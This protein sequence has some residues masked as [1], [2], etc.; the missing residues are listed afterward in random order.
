MIA[1]TVHF[2][3]KTASAKI[4]DLL[5]DVI[6]QRGSYVLCRSLEDNEIGKASS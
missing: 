6:A 2:T 3:K 4:S 1:N 5:V